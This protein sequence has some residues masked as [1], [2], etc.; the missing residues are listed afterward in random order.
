MDRLLPQKELQ[1]SR[2][3]EFL[4]KQQFLRS[5]HE[6]Y[7]IYWVRKFM[8][9]PVEITAQNLDGRSPLIPPYH[10]RAARTQP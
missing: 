10:T 2:F 3:G 4:L 8:T 9:R 1:A 6:R 7:L 5:G